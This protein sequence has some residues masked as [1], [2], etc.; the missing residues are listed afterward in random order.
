[1]HRDSFNSVQCKDG[2]GTGGKIR[3]YTF[4]LFIREARVRL[5]EVL[6]MI[7]KHARLKP[8]EVL[9]AIVQETLA[10]VQEEG[11]ILRM[12]QRQMLL[13]NINNIQNRTRPQLPRNITELTITSP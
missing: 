12:P 1:M 10:N 6:N 8:N 2:H 9:L 4:T 5:N 7:E 11:M 13:R 3:S